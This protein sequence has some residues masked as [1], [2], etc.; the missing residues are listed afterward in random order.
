[1]TEILAY[2]PSEAAKVLAVSRDVIFRLI[3]DGSIR[4]TKIGSA[5]IIPAGELEAFLARKLDESAAN[6]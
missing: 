6:A 3:A 1:M 4:S 5:R 2:R